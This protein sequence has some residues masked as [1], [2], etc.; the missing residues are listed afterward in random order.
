VV[1]MVKGIVLAVMMFGCAL[2]R[3]M[4][5]IGWAA[6]GQHGAGIKGKERPDESG[7]EAVMHGWR[8]S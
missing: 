6:R 3:R 5:S 4:M 1:G 7:G 8:F 2:V